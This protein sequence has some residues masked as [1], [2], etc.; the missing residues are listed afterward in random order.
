MRKFHAHFI[1]LLVLLWALM[2]SLP[3]S[4]MAQSAQKQYDIVVV[5]DG[6]GSISIP[7]FELER[8]YAGSL[9]NSCVL[10]AD[11]QA[12]LVQFSSTVVTEIALTSDLNRVRNA[13]F[14]MRQ[15]GGATNTGGGL[16][17]ADDLLKASKRS[18]QQVV[19][20][21]T[22]GDANIG[23]DPV[24]VGTALRN[25]GVTVY[26]VGVGNLNQAE[27]Q[28]I[29][30]PNPIYT[31]ANFGDLA[32]TLGA[33]VGD[34]CQAPVVP[35][36]PPKGQKT[37]LVAISQEPNPNV[38]AVRDSI[39]AYTVVI[40]NHGKGSADNVSA[41]MPFDPAEVRFRDASFTRDTAWITKVMTDSIRFDTGP[42]GK[43][44]DVITGTIR[45]NV[46]GNAPIGNSLSER[47][48]YTWLNEVRSRGQ[49]KSNATILTV[50]GANNHRTLYSLQASPAKGPAGSTHT[51]AS[52]IFV[53]NEPISLWYN[54]PDGKAIE[55]ER[56]S[57]DS[58]GM[59]SAP[60]TT[61]GLARGTY[62][63]VAHGNWSGFRA[64][65]V[66]IVE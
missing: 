10:G 41:A 20:L 19:V 61:A 18:V 64:T 33:L 29:V 56:V 66:F 17:R 21:I 2:P 65:T 39:V 3:S 53:P 31:A 22:D 58:E 27:L 54:T 59:L 36:T 11:T 48:S 14:G 16:Q 52:G 34:V 44:G 46:L 55:I 6:S 51:F 30:G 50:A 8:I 57:A 9:L 62:S 42:L 24:A 47:I 38:G 15:L 32:A 12:G 49:G 40:T 1:A 13:V 25:R 23:P 4:A 35:I 43:A 45:F 5:V 63:M 28:N 37:A 60:F 26:G 7:D